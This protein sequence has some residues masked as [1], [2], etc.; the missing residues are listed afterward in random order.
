MDD[1]TALHLA[2]A[3]GNPELVQLLCESR[4]DIEAADQYGNRPLHRG[5]AHAEVIRLLLARGA[6]EAVRGGGRA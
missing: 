2:A 3:M 4:G 6:P 5:A 1:E